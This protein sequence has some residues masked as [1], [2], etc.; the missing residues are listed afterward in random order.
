M[1]K[2]EYETERKN[3]CNKRSSNNEITKYIFIYI[4]DDPLRT[5]KTVNERHGERE[6]DERNTYSYV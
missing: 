3:Y 1:G 2:K 5:S 4:K 6:R